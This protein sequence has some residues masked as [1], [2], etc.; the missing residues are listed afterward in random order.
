[1]PVSTRHM[2]NGTHISA[3]RSWA[4]VLFK[5]L[6]E[7]PHV[8]I[9]RFDKGI[10]A[11]HGA[12]RGGE[13]GGLGTGLLG[14]PLNQ[15]QVTPRLGD[16]G[17]HAVLLHQ[18]DELDDVIRGRGNPGSLLDGPDLDEPE[19]SEQIDPHGMIDDDRGALVERQRLVPAP[20]GFVETG[21][22][23]LP[24]ALEG[25]AMLRRDSHETF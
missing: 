3:R 6:G 16:D 7:R 14:Y 9:D 11:L 18:A 15:L 19:A 21:K 12:Y 17:L 4:T 13:D 22:E 20:H 8:E 24:V 2:R 5:H 25:G 10:G 23:L 1:M